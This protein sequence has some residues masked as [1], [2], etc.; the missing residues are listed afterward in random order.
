[1]KTD[2]NKVYCE[3]CGEIKTKD[4]I[5]KGYCEKHLK[6]HIDKPEKWEEQLDK[7]WYL[8][9]MNRYGGVTTCGEEVK[10]FVRKLLSQQKE[11]LIGKIEGMKT[12]GNTKLDATAEYVNNRL[13]D[14]IKIIKDYD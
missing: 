3:D 8:H 10:D 1:M 13:D 11:E 6:E 9:T 4:K 12:L 14:I 2:L 7:K 5:Y